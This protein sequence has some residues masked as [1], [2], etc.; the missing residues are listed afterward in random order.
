MN[1]SKSL[2]WKL[3]YFN[4]GFYNLPNPIPGQYI[5]GSVYYVQFRL[6]LPELKYSLCW[7]LVSMQLHLFQQNF[8]WSISSVGNSRRDVPTHL[9]NFASPDIQSQLF[10]LVD[11]LSKLSN[12]FSECASLQVIVAVRLLHT[13]PGFEMLDSGSVINIISQSVKR[14]QSWFMHSVYNGQDSW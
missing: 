14:E 6:L 12:N 9:N 4:P 2:F 5:F 1:I 13:M 7:G 10:W 8:F 3:S 11:Y